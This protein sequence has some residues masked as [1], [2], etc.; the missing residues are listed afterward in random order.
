MHQPCS[1][2]LTPQMLHILLKHIPLL[3]QAFLR[4]GM[5]QKT[6]TECQRSCSICS[7]LSVYLLFISTWSG[8]QRYRTLVAL[9]SAWPSDAG[10]GWAVK[11]AGCQAECEAGCHTENTDSRERNPRNRGRL[12]KPFKTCQD[13]INRIHTISFIQVWGKPFSMLI[14][15]KKCLHASSKSLLE[16]DSACTWQSILDNIFDSPV[17]QSL[18]VSFSAKLQRCASQNKMTTIWTQNYPRNECKC[19]E[20]C[21]K[22]WKNEKQAET[23]LKCIW[24]SIPI[25]LGVWPVAP[26]LKSAQSS[27]RH[28]RFQHWVSWVFGLA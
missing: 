24:Q 16:T 23:S 20:R 5:S 1:L 25:N 2:G 28:C 13:H 17:L 15:G 19:S 10:P 6:Q 8:S 7:E 9:L 18:S 11:Q 21:W 27:Q 3:P 26:C 22:S 12:K 14:F 4:H